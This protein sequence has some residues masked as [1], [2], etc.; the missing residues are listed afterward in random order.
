MTTYS[1]IQGDMWDM[2]AFKLTGSYSGMS[3]LMKANPDHMEIVIFP[4]GIVLNV[5]VFTEGVADTLPPWL[6]GGESV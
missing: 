1:T 3:E 2:I 4:A 5:P 6:I